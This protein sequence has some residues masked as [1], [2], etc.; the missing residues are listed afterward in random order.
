MEDKNAATQLNLPNVQSIGS[1]LSI[2]DHE[3]ALQQVI[4]NPLSIGEVA[5]T[6]TE[7]QKWFVLKRLHFDALV[8]LEELPPQATFMFEKIEQM[9]IEEA[10][11]ILEKNIKEHETDVNIPEN[12]LIL[13]KELVEMSHKHTKAELQG[14]VRQQF[15]V[16]SRR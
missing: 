15:F 12:D 16:F 7:S 4:D 11:E 13:W 10:V 1:H 9:T 6:L 3:I 14:K 5:T 8:S 2:Q